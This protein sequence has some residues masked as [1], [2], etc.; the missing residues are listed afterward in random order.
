MIKKMKIYKDI[1]KIKKEEFLL[2]SV[3]SAYILL[4][5]FFLEKFSF[6]YIPLFLFE[7]YLTISVYNGIKKNVYNERFSFFEI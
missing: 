5:N 4:E 3:L 2:F 1:L 6:A 7:I